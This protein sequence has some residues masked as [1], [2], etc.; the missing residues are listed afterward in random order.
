MSTWEEVRDAK[1]SAAARAEVDAKVQL[2]L[3]LMD[4]RELRKPLG[5]T[6]AQIAKAWRSAETATA[7]ERTHLLPTIRRVVE[8]LGGELEVIANFGTHRVRLRGV[9]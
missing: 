9:L 1:L 6:Q 2:E 4:L 3:L 7:P 8:A 5:V